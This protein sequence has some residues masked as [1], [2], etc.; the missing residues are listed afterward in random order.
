MVGGTWWAVSG[1][2]YMVGSE[3]WA[4]GNDFF[5]RDCIQNDTFNVRSL[6][7]ECFVFINVIL[8]NKVVVV[9]YVVNDG[10]SE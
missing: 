9:V 8:V 10:G 1:G 5:A 2:W 7:V 3:W 4:V 6:M